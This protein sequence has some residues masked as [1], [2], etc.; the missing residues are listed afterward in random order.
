[1]N[2]ALSPGDGGR[3]RRAPTPAPYLAQV[4]KD[5]SETSKEGIAGPTMKGQVRETALRR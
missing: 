5:H 4:L 3:G 1:M 2:T